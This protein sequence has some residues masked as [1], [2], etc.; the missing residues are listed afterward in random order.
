MTLKADCIFCKIAKKEIPSGIVFEDDEVV[1]F[2]D[3]N[4]Q[5][6]VHLL[7]VPK[8]HIARTSDLKEADARLIANLILAAKTLA[9]QQGL[10]ESGYRIVLNCGKDAGQEVFHLHMHLLG[11]RKFTWP[12]G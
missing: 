12:P 8:R 2:K 3:K 10:D 7:I 5:S 1:A 6:P 11:G 4:P 9:S